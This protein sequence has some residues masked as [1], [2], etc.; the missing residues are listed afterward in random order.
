[1]LGPR[2]Q[3]PESLREGLSDYRIAQDPAEY[4]ELGSI[5]GNRAPNGRSVSHAP[6]PKIS[7]AHADRI[8]GACRSGNT[9][10]QASSLAIL[11]FSNADSIAPARLDLLGLPTGSL[12]R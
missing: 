2:E 1:M 6:S 8:P 12:R 7:S 3:V 5:P 4:R 10:S 11:T 9:R